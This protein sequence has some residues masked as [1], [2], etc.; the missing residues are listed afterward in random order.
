MPVSRQLLR[1]VRG[2]LIAFTFLFA[3]IINLLPWQVGLANFTPDFVALF[4]VYWSLNQ[5]RRVGIA[6]AFV[7]GILMD[8]GDGNVLGQHAFAYVVISYLTLARQRQLNIFP[9][10]QQAFVALGFLWLSQLLM[11]LIRLALG[12]PFVGWG[13]F[14]GSVLSALLWTPLSNILMMYQRK[15][16]SESI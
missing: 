12:S 11:I 7:L 6:W 3:L 9:F 16:K 4:I 14:A 2:T 5:P 15:P 8:V 10:W 13:Y 1:P